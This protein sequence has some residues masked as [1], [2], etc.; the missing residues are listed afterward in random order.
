MSMD[1]EKYN[2]CQ[3]MLTAVSSRS[4]EKLCARR[5]LFQLLEH[6]LPSEPLCS[7]LVYTCQ[8]LSVGR[9]VNL[10]VIQLF[11]SLESWGKDG[12]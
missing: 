2:S 8:E 12:G 9:Q 1:R 10:F 4:A 3:C 6:R 7:N 5:A 11:S